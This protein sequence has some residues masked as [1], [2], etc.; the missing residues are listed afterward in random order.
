M[1]LLVFTVIPSFILS[2]LKMSWQN[3]GIDRKLAFWKK[4]LLGILG[5]FAGEITGVAVFPSANS[6]WCRDMSAQGSHCDGQGGL[7][8]IF[9]VPLCA[10]I[11]SC[12]SILW[13]WISVTIPAK[14]PWA[15]I[16]NYGGG[17]RAMNVVFAVA[18]QALYWAI[19]ALAIYRFTRNLL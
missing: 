16:F 19:F 2:G 10:I 4:F 8:L 3:D 1:F 5:G 17:N 12:A 6:N 14:K 9:T 18:V 11:G 15:S 13:T 7:V